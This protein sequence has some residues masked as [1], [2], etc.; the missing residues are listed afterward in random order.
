MKRKGGCVRYW[1]KLLYRNESGCITIYTASFYFI[2][3][4]ALH[5]IIFTD[6]ALIFFL[7]LRFFQLIRILA[8]AQ[9]DLR[10]FLCTGNSEWYAEDAERRQAQTAA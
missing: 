3:D 6:D 2:A 4:D 5:T 7:L 9:F 1:I 8:S 10:R